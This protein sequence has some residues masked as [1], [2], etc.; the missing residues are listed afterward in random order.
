MFNGKFGVSVGDINMAVCGVRLHIFS[1]SLDSKYSDSS[2]EVARAECFLVL[3]LQSTTQE[4]GDSSVYPPMKPLKSFDSVL[5][6][7][8]Q[9]HYI[10]SMTAFHQCRAVL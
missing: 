5:T 8:F 9:H 4:E 3:K 1:P 6:V 2:E 10:G 7:W